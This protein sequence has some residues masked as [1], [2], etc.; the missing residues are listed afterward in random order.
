MT[1]DERHQLQEQADRRQRER[2][3]AV[4]RSVTKDPDEQRV[5]AFLI[6]LGDA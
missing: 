5:I 1:D 2:A 6:V 4:A 3:C